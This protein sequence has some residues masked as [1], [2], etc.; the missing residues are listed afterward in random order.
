MLVRDFYGGRL[1]KALQRL[2]VTALVEWAA[3]IEAS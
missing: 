1:M 3:L 2:V